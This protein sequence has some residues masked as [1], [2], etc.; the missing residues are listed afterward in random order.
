MPFECCKVTYWATLA[1]ADV[2]IFICSENRGLISFGDPCTE[3]IAQDHIYY[4]NIVKLGNTGTLAST[5]MHSLISSRN[6][7]S[8]SL[9][10]YAEKTFQ[11]CQE[12]CLATLPK[13]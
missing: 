9:D 4:L 7:G 12:R 5:Y 1:K 13:A 2:H 6:A 8:S 11:I 3:F 10:T